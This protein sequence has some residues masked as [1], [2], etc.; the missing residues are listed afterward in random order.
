MRIIEWNGVVVDG[1]GGG[2]EEKIKEILVDNGDLIGGIKLKT[3]VSRTTTKL[4][5]LVSQSLPENQRYKKEFSTW[6]DFENSTIY[7]TTILSDYVFITDENDLYILSSIGAG[8]LKNWTS[9]K[10]DLKSRLDILEAFIDDEA[11][12]D[13][14]VNKVAEVLKVFENYPEGVNILQELNNIKASILLKANS[15]DVY[16]K[17]QIDNYLNLKADK[18]TTYTK[19]EVN[20]ELD[21]KVDKEV[22]KGLSQENYTAI[23]KTKLG[24]I[25][26]GAE[27]NV[28][29]DWNAT[30][31]DAEILNKPTIPN[32]QIQSDFNQTDNTKLDFIKN[33]PNL[34]LKQDKIYDI[35]N[36]EA[37]IL[38][39]TDI[40]NVGKFALATD[41]RKEYKGIDNSGVLNWQL[42]IVSDDSK[43]DK[44]KKDANNG[45]VGLT[46]FKIN[47]RNALNTFTSFIQS[48]ATA[49]RT[50][51]LQDKTGTIAHLD[52]LDSK[53]NEITTDDG[54]RYVSKNGNDVNTG[55]SLNS[56][57]KTLQSAQDSS[58]SSGLI[59]VEGSY[60][61]SNLINQ[62]SVNYNNLTISKETLSII[63]EGFQNGSKYITAWKKWTANTL[64]KTGD[65]VNDPSTDTLGGKSYIS[66]SNR[67]TGAIWNA[68]EIANFD[69][70]TTIHRIKTT[71]SRSCFR[72]ISSRGYRSVVLENAGSLGGVIQFE[73]CEVYIYLKGTFNG[74][75]EIFGGNCIVECD[76]SLNASLGSYIK[77]NNVAD[78]KATT[79]SNIN[80]NI[81]NSSFLKIIHNGTGML[82]LQN[83][84]SVQSIV[85]NVNS[86]IIPVLNIETAGFYL[87]GNNLNYLD[88]TGSKPTIL[89]KNGNCDHYIQNNIG[90]SLVEQQVGYVLNGNSIVY[91]KNVYNKT[92]NPTSTDDISK[93]FGIGSEWVMSNGTI[94]KCLSS[95]IGSAIWQDQND[96]LESVQDKTT[97]EQTYLLGFG[98]N[99]SNYV[100]KYITIN[101]AD[102]LRSANTGSNVF[103][104][105]RQATYKIISGTSGNTNSQLQFISSVAPSA[106]GGGATWGGIAGSIANQADLLTEL[107][108]KFDKTSIQTSFQATP[109]NDKVASEKLVKDSLDGKANDNQVVKLTGNQT[110][111]GNKTFSNKVILD[112]LANTSGELKLLVRDTNTKEIK[113]QAIQDLVGDRYKTT[114][115]DS[116]TISNSGQLTFNVETGLSY[117]PKQ[118]VIILYDALNY[119]NGEVSSYDNL[120]GIL[121][122]DIK[123]KTGSGT[124]SSWKIALDGLQGQVLGNYLDLDAS[125]QISGLTAKTSLVDA[126]V[127]IAENSANSFSKIKI[128]LSNL[129][130]YIS[131]KVLGTDNTFTGS[132]TFT[133]ELLITNTAGTKKTI[134]QAGGMITISAQDLKDYSSFVIT[135]VSG[136]VV[137]IATPA[138][139]AKTKEII[140]ELTLS[141]T[142]S[143]Q[144]GGHTLSSSGGYKFAYV[145]SN[146]RFT[147]IG[148]GIKA[149][150]NEQNVFT[151]GNIFNAPPVIKSVQNNEALTKFL[152]L[153]ED[154]QIN[155][156]EKM[157]HNFVNIKKFLPT[158]S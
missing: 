144:V 150:L 135:G 122:V 18:T 64:I 116:Q 102:G 56:P 153:G 119:M 107:N 34:A 125:N 70:N 113:E 108:K 8:G 156:R 28:N 106:S 22:G 27:V 62:P 73:N 61:D 126:D 118:D 100:G 147:E 91:P 146:W 54:K 96:I 72:G 94:F 88:T 79:Y 12:V 120:T 117:I 151:G 145:N 128:A 21:K 44:N 87:I 6:T 98:G 43:E 32:A 10:Q 13:G 140:I 82:G 5:D 141:G 49:S 67:T 124:Y 127:L 139:T 20:I 57:K 55:Y 25:Q 58:N 105:S 46:N 142:A 84:L 129:Y 80:L 71:K 133:K 115:T 14:I 99:T 154:D 92:T 26:E 132:N 2:L 75:L 1:G 3:W 86:N 52:D 59:Y 53:A 23:E 103:S 123:S 69:E 63:A 95:T 37:N 30:S 131:S 137:N 134:P 68:S 39:I 38:L 136:N 138:D 51:T 110:I 83:N 40:S 15:S 47:I 90:L 11:D 4:L 50:Y 45:Y 19:T 31:G 77:I 93:Y 121:I 66:K 74:G 35:L 89:Q 157:E 9:L 36:T 101:N 114:S 104:D 149:G 111:A 33:K 42:Q 130:S 85:S 143:I 41:T 81:I 148:A 65:I 7:A 17:V 76:A 158:E 78:V 109:T 24:G 29:A 97:L 48:F 155:Y 16:T 152:V 112:G 60:Q